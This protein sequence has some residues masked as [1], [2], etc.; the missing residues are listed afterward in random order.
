MIEYYCNQKGIWKKHI[1]TDAYGNN[2]YADPV[3]IPCRIEN[4]TKLIRTKD[5]KE[6]LSDTK[7]LTKLQIKADD[8]FNERVVLYVDDMVDFDGEVIGYEVRL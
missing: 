5:G 3:E 1:D 6:T 8:L 2:V 4:K 7:I